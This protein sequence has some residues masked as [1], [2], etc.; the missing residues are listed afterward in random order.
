MSSIENS[1]QGGSTSNDIQKKLKETSN[2]V[3]RVQ[4]EDSSAY[5]ITPPLSPV[6]DKTASIPS[7]INSQVHGYSHPQPVKRISPF[8]SPFESQVNSE[9][10]KVDQIGSYESSEQQVTENDNQNDIVGAIRRQSIAQP[11]PL[12]ELERRTSVGAYPVAPAP[13]PVSQSQD[14]LERRHVM[15]ANQ[16][17]LPGSIDTNQVSSIQSSGLPSGQSVASPFPPSVNGAPSYDENDPNYIQMIQR[18]Q[19]AQQQ[20]QQANQQATAVAAGQTQQGQPTPNSAAS[21]SASTQD[22]QQAQQSPNTTAQNGQVAQVA[23]HYQQAYG[24][25]QIVGQHQMVSHHQM[26]P[27]PGMIP[28]Q[29]LQ[30]SGAHLATHPAYMG[31]PSQYQIY[32]PMQDQMHNGQYYCPPGHQPGQFGMTANG[33]VIPTA[34]QQYLHQQQQ[35][36]LAAQVAQ[37]AASNGSRY[38]TGIHAI[39][40]EIIGIPYSPLAFIEPFVG[41]VYESRSETLLSVSARA[42]QFGFE[43]LVRTSKPHYVVLICGCGRKKPISRSKSQRRVQYIATGCMWR[44]VVEK[45]VKNGEEGWRVRPGRFMDHNHELPLPLGR[46]VFNTGA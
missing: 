24:T 1:T 43:A 34:H 38:V 9:E 16:G 11:S 21:T 4:N 20:V 31:Y 19:S 46:R 3:Q 6:G 8:A 33:M 30:M 45:S 40:P 23:G 22:G 15:Y 37:H 7:A 5:V 32:Q 14:L 12:G 13:Y 27:H 39:L 25:P 18:Q 41:N 36:T 42:A 28:Q 10:N 35:H 17:S 29:H 2:A 44:C 26:P